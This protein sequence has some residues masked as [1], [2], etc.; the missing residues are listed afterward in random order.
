MQ[1]M[2]DKLLVFDTIEIIGYSVKKN[3]AF[4]V[5]NQIIWAFAVKFSLKS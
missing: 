2:L 4:K 1:Y 5:R 3:Y